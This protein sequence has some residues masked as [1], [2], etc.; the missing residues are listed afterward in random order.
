M[1]SNNKS[2]AHIN[3]LLLCASGQKPVAS[4]TILENDIS[5]QSKD[6]AYLKF[7]LKMPAGSES[8]VLVSQPGKILYFC[9]DLENLF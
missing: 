7:T 2:Q 4:A 6:S 9:T 1:T 5:K 8:H 3:K